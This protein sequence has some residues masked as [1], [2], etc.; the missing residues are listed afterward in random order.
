[1]LRNLWAEGKR[2]RDS[3][4]MRWKTSFQRIIGYCKNAFK[5]SDYLCTRIPCS[6]WEWRWKRIFE[7]NKINTCWNYL[8][9]FKWKSFSCTIYSRAKWLWVLVSWKEGAVQRL[10]WNMTSTF[11][12][13]PPQ[14]SVDFMYPL[15]VIKSALA[16]N[17]NENHPD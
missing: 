9:P 17:A 1:M 6:A 11:G 16:A 4:K 14:A 13:W 7:F 15:N 10:E 3:D 12:Y 5:N 2:R 8:I